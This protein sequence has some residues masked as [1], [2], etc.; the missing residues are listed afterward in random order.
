[1]ASPLAAA[2]RS[3][4]A[5]S[6]RAVGMPSAKVRPRKTRVVPMVA[7]VRCVSFNV[8]KRPK[9]IRY[10]RGSTST[11]TRFSS[12]RPTSWFCWR[13]RTASAAEAGG[14]PKNEICTIVAR[15]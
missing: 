14:P 10:Y 7:W 5:D 6:S 2:Y 4:T 15:Q 1:M 12:S 11:V 9:K 8:A 13:I 3:L